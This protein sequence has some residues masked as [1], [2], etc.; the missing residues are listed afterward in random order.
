MGILEAPGGTI[1]QIGQVGRVSRSTL[2]SRTRRRIGYWIIMV[3]LAPVA[4]IMIVPF[5][6][7][8]L[9]SFKRPVEILRP[10]ITWLPETFYT[11]GY[12]RN[13]AGGG[14]PGRIR[15]QPVRVGRFDNC[16]AP[17]ER[18]GWLY[19]REEELLRK[20]RA[21]RVCSQHHHGPRSSC[22]SFPRSFSTSS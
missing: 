19:L 8:Y 2:Y 6:W 21:F 15:E 4:A 14:D 9:S 1:D 7:M 11:Q 13:V 22:S 3:A 16:G 17:N 10:T 5:V 20:K 18:P 12:V